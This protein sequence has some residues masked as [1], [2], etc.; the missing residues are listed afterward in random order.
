MVKSIAHKAVIAGSNPAVQNWFRFSR[1][2]L[3]AYRQWLDGL[4]YTEKV[5]GSSPAVPTMHWDRDSIGGS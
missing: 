5:A 1:R 4:V 2:Y 3:G